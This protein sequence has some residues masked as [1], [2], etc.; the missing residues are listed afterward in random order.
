MQTGAEG[1]TLTE[2]EEN[3]VWT[4]AGAW[5]Q[6]EEGASFGRWLGHGI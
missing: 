2:D 6:A 3:L 1:W 4:M 5:D